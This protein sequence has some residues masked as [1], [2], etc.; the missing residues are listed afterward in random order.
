MKNLLITFLFL[1]SL[2]AWSQNHALI[3]QHIGAED[4]IIMPIVVSTDS[5]T[6]YFRSRHMLYTSTSWKIPF[7]LID[8]VV[9]S[10]T[11]ILK[12]YMEAVLPNVEKDC[13][14]QIKLWSH[15]FGTLSVRVIYQDSVKCTHFIDDVN[16]VSFLKN[17][18][19]KICSIDSITDLRKPTQNMMKR[20]GHIH[21]ECD[22]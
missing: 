19:L 12:I 3:I 2:E 7:T 14:T 4:R 18:H 16:C 6:E 9:M 1:S 8:N 5:I 22:Y 10:E 21:D 15:P 13:N 20:F 11:K 17:F